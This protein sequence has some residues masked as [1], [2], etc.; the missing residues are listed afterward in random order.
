LST[1]I[2]VIIP[3]YNRANLLKR[4]IDSVIN[5]TYK[6]WE[7]LIVDNFSTD[8]T[9]E[10]LKNYKDSRISIFKIHNTGVI[11]K[12]RNLG[13]KKSS[14]DWI[15]FLDSDD[16]WIKTKLEICFRNINL[17]T[18]LIYHKLFIRKNNRNHCLF[19]KSLTTKKLNKPIMNNLLLNG[20]LINNS[21]VVVRKK[22]IQNV[23]GIS[24]KKELIAAED[25]NLWLKISE[26]TENFKFINKNLGYYFIHEK[27]ILRQDMSIPTREASMAYIK[28]LSYS[29][30][31]LWYANLVYMSARYCYLIKDYEKANFLLKSILSKLDKQKKFKTLFMLLKIFIFNQNQ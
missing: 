8:H 19:N 18:D 20:N 14:G 29:E 9:D 24:E 3:T 25:Y 5:Q 26:T 27:N 6:N 15:A 30:K 2:S 23:Q 12:S 7:L 17:K 1:K 31:K 28:I 22:I 11:A 21:S 13:I 10:V 16:W 4:A